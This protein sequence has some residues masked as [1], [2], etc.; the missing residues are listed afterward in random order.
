MISI[1][2]CFYL[3]K[4]RVLYDV[5]YSECT[6]SSGRITIL[7]DMSFY[8]ITVGLLLF[9]VENTKHMIYQ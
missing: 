8:F 5:L 4:V 6:K 3:S 9:Q 7:G 1:N 2:K